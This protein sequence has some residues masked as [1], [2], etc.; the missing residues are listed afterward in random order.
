M[1]A[2]IMNSLMNWK[3]KFIRDQDGTNEVD[4]RSFDWVQGLTSIFE[5]LFIKIHA[6]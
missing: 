3:E 6:V 5:K 2:K 4:F 1:N